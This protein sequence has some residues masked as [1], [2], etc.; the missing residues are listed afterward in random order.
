MQN[1]AILRLYHNP[2]KNK[3]E[4]WFPVWFVKPETASIKQKKF[5]SMFNAQRLGV[6]IS[7]SEE[8][9][10]HKY[11]PRTKMEINRENTSFEPQHQHFE[12]H[13]CVRPALKHIHRKQRWLIPSFSMNFLHRFFI[14]KYVQI[15]CF[16]VI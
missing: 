7:Q 10:F 15:L 8:S 11:H 1:K 12:E 2:N 3:I 5:Q 13:R 4:S 16:S 14:S 9:S 6:Q